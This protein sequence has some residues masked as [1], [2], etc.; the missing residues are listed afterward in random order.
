M[1]NAVR[2]GWPELA[3]PNVSTGNCWGSQA[4]PN[5]RPMLE[6]LA[7][8]SRQSAVWRLKPAGLSFYSVPHPVMPGTCPESHFSFAYLPGE[9][10]VVRFARFKVHGSRYKE[11]R[12]HRDDAGCAEC[13]VR[14]DIPFA[15]ASHP[16][17]DTVIRILC[18]VRPGEQNFLSSVFC[19]L[20]SGMQPTADCRLPTA[21][22]QYG[23]LTP[24]PVAAAIFR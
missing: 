16:K 7:V 13:R 15:K 6:K 23:R 14:G 12:A 21:N 5:L 3:R 22:L 8:G 2:P 17:P 20:S 9:K 19:P 10:S 11:F 24:Q 1:Q 18:T 4:H